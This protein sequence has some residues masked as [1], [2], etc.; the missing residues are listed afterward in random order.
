MQGR[1]GVALLRPSQIHHY[2]YGDWQG[3]MESQECLEGNFKIL[4][5]D[6]PFLFSNSRR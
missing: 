6:P 2:I 3:T 4:D 5:L 1:V